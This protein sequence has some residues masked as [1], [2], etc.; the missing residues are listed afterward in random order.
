M[1]NENG[2]GSNVHEDAAL[3]AEA[4]NFT[5]A[6]TGFAARLIEKDYFA[7]MLLRHLCSG[8]TDLVF[9]GG[10]CLSK[11]YWGLSRLSEDLDFSVAVPLDATRGQRREAA[12][13]MKQA[14]SAIPATLG[15]FRHVEALRG[16]NVS[17]Q[18]VSVLSY[19]SDR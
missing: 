12:S 14:M 15:A 2:A 4:I 8:S 5:S 18:Y 11:V 3:F 9:K 19:E 10:T 7:S 16:F 6:T 13:P 1:P 17:T